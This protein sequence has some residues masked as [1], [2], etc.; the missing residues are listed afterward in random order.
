MESVADVEL[1]SP[2]SDNGN[3]HGGRIGEEGPD[4]PDRSE[5][6]G[7]AYV[8]DIP[9]PRTGQADVG[10]TQAAPSAQPVP[11]DVGGESGVVDLVGRG[12]DDGHGDPPL[13]L[14]E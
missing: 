14:Q 1:T 10:V 12:D 2:G 3:G 11:L 9:R 13:F 7:E 4:R 6:D 8:G 5:L